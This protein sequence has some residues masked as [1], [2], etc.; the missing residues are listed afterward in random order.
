MKKHEDLTIFRLERFREKLK[1]SFYPEK[2]PLKS[3]YIWSSEPIPFEKAK[4]LKYESIDTETKWGSTFDCAW[5]RFTGQVPDSRKGTEV[6]ALIDLG[7]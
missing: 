7:G 4:Q 6:I 2:I 1:E 3:E 5:F